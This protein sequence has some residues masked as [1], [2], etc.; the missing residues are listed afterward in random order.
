MNKLTAAGSGGASLPG[1]LRAA[2]WGIVTGVLFGL[3]ARAWMRLIALHPEFSWSGSIAI[4]IVSVLFFT[5]AFVIGERAAAGGSRWWGWLMVLG[6]GVF[7][8]QG[9]TLFPGA[10]AASVAVSDW[11]S[12]SAR[13][14][15]LLGLILAAGWVWRMSWFDEAT[16][17]SMTG[18]QQVILVLGYLGLAWTLGTGLS[19]LWRLTRADQPADIPT[20]GEL[21]A[22]SAGATL[23]R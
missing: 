10:L 4:M 22:P 13:I 5:S 9:A 20:E 6:L 2:C 16:Y 14:A 1:P 15:G 12:K 17:L 19:W 7:M 18:S 3:G 11:L 8:A 23:S 21:P